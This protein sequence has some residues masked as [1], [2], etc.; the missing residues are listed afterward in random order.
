[1]THGRFYF[2]MAIS[3][4]P[5]QP[6]PSGLPKLSESAE[7]WSRLDKTSIAELGIFSASA[8]LK[9]GS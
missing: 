7:K 5:S 4:S 9:P 3:S 8:W 6:A 2:D 1:M